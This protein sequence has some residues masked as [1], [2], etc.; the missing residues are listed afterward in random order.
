M[1]VFFLKISVYFY[2]TFHLLISNIF[3]LITSINIT[4]LHILCLVLNESFQIKIKHSNTY[5]TASLFSCHTPYCEKTRLV[6]R[7]SL[8]QVYI[9]SAVSR[10][11]QLRKAKTSVLLP[12]SE[13]G[14]RKG[15]RGSKRVANKMLMLRVILFLSYLLF[16]VCTFGRYFF[17]ACE[18]RWRA[19]PVGESLQFVA[20]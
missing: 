14:A 5:S 20:R 2:L 11:L 15:E 3:N 19:A 17:L 9:R 16:D 12:W 6:S 8:V 18:G 7:Y 1:I 4:H 10:V 13:C